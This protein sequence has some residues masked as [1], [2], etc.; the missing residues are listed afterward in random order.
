MS[1]RL[2]ACA[3]YVIQN[4]ILDVIEMFVL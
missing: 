2:F 4:G 1:I 3:N